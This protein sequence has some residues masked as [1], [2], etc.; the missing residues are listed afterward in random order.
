MKTNIIT[1]LAIITTLAPGIP[2][3]AAASAHAKSMTTPTPAQ[4]KITAATVY[5]DRAIVTRT[6]RIDLP[7]GET[8]VTLEKLPASLLD[9]SVQ[10]SGRGAAGATILDVS[11]RV[12]YVNNTAEID[13]PKV[14]A[15]QEEI[16]A[17]EQA[18]RKLDDRRAVLKQQSKLLD[19]IEAVVIATPPP[20]SSTPPPT[21]ENLQKLMTF[22]GEKRA[23][24]AADTQALDLEF[25]AAKQQLTTLRSRLN[26]ILAGARPDN[27]SYKTVTVRVAAAKAGPL[28]LTVAYA[29][30]NASWSPSYDARM[31]TDER[32]VELTYFGIVR[33]STGEDWDG[34]A[35]TLSTARPSL[36]SSAPALN[37][38]ILDV[39]VPR[40]VVMMDKSELNQEMRAKKSRDNAQVFFNVAAGAAA[41]AMEFEDESKQDAALATAT[42]DSTA[43]SA[44]FK[45]A[46]TTTIPS[47]NTP[48]KVSITVK[49][50]DAKLQYQATPAMQETAFL[51]AYVTN[52]TDF[53][54]LAGPANIF[55]DNAFVSTSALKSVM[56][57][58]KFEVSLGADEGVAIKRR[59]V[60]RFSE[61]TGLI[62]KGRRVTYEFLVTITNNKK[63]PERVVFKEALPLS[64]NEKIVV[65][66]LTPVEK[67]VGTLEKP[68][69]EVTKEEDSKLVWRLD[70]AAGEKREIPLKFSVDYPSDVQVTGLE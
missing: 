36:G 51:S 44:T 39:H 24:L 46:A 62:G 58:E 60:N 7:A 1:I 52:T 31:R 5:T 43:T 30:P 25:N 65:K 45:I 61:N 66:L 68:G 42:V 18:L 33:Q 50:L 8:H 32:A 27:R 37:P 17:T 11:T 47:D 63:T 57:T 19:Q 15:L 70:L 16:N 59:I 55:L 10:V 13:Q 48:Q 12:T 6:A 41:P 26:T 35:L 3:A 34:I 49:K 14:A 22:S 69:R 54:L 67:D 28:D 40:P 9:A 64:R 2:F 29:V 20:G 53:P 4:S 38:W 56:P 23:Q 21:L